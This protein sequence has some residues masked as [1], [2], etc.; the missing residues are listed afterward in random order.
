MQIKKHLSTYMSVRTTYLFLFCLIVATTGYAKNKDSQRWSSLPALAYNKESGLVYGILGYYYLPRKELDIHPS[1]LRFLAV[2]TTKNQYQLKWTPSIYWGNYALVGFL[3]GY[4]WPAKFYG[5]G[6]HSDE[7]FDLYRSQ[8]F[9]GQLVLQR[10]FSHFFMGLGGHWLNESIRWE[11]QNTFTPTQPE[12]DNGG[13]VAGVLLQAGY[14]TRDNPNAPYKGHWI[15]GTF[16]IYPSWPGSSFSYQ[17][18]DFRWSHYASLFKKGVLA[19]GSSWESHVG[20]APFRQW[21]TPDG[22]DVLR[23]VEKGRYRD[24]ILWNIQAEL[25]RY[26]I[27]HKRLG[28]VLFTEFSQ[29]QSRWQAIQFGEFKGS[30]GM[31]LR[32]VLNPVRRSQ[33]RMDI[34]WVDGNAQYLLS[35]GEAF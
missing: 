12:G 34:S 15:K 35:V 19:L 4:I 18:Q 32:Y 8:G 10:Y 33:V 23:G 26:G 31:G 24:R 30:Y 14:D 20:R 17:T 29:V 11:S 16:G 7:E 2:G 13:N 5:L 9:E 6:N 21:S 25:R 3:Q 27:F 1:N 22:V 28:G